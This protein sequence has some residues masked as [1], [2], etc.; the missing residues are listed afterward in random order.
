MARKRWLVFPHDAARVQDLERT[1]GI[2]PVVAQLLLRRKI[3]E[4]DLARR[5][6]EPRLNDLREPNALPGL[7]AAAAI[8]HQAVKDQKKIVV[9]GDYDADGMTA[10]AILVGCLRLL[11]GQ[12]S[13][14]VP[15]RLDDGYGLNNEAISQLHDRGAQMLVTVDCGIA[16]VECA[17]HAKDL[18]LQLVITDHHQFGS[19][20]P[21]ADALVHPA[22]PG[23]D[24][25]FAGL[26]GAAVAFKLAWSICQLA[27]N[28]PRVNPQ[29][30]DFLLMAL[31]L[32][33]I[34][35]VCDVVPLVDE[36]RIIVR[37]GLACIKTHACPGL[38]SLMTVAGLDPTKQ[39]A[40]EDLAFKIGPRLNAAGRLGQAQLG[41]ELLTSD[42]LPRVA[43]LA[44]YLQQL[45]L[46]RDSL[47]RSIHLSANKQIKDQFDGDNDPAFVL[48][49]RDWHAGVIG[50][51]AGRISEK[52]HRPTL[53]IS[54]DSLGAKP[55]IGSGRSASGL[56]LY[57]ALH[58]CREHLVSFGGHAAAAGFKIDADRIEPFRRA[59]CDYVADQV[60]PQERLAELH[61]DAEATL[62][63][64]TLDTLREVERLA[65]FGQANPR[66]ILCASQ[67]HLVE[68]PR[69]MG[70]NERHLSMRIV[71][72]GVK[73]R[74]VAFGRADWADHLPD[75]ALPIDLAF[76]PVINE[77][78]GYRKVE[79]QLL[80]WRLSTASVCSVGESAAADQPPDSVFCK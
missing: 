39:L 55:G 77:F 19:E 53:M 66:P 8:I 75:P 80:D 38:R 31:G 34:G 16:S 27:S 74:A 6:L 58:H 51:V 17:R 7:E 63:Q 79:M 69:R 18:G 78:N 60:G 49:D 54:I 40:S 71:Q 24:Y 11:G 37:H 10:T 5:F 1:L 70:A 44:E 62:S 65:P 22:L 28:A 20:L 12:V 32:A 46:S 73:M 72:H 15:S 33:A 14:F 61:I 57:Q 50:I 9:Y 23:S 56:D 59:F 47:D 36:N 41:V 4:P 35:T 76:H 68:A 2:S 29:L 13:Y 45:N 42:Q 25:P 21:V 30:R 67:V 48:A 3:T 43:A 26:C 64:L 52:F